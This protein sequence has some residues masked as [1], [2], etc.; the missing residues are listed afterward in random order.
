MTGDNSGV[1][2]LKKDDT[3][4]SEPTDQVEVLN[5]QFVSAVTKEDNISMPIMGTSTADN[6]ATPQALI[7]QVNGVKKLPF[8]SESTQS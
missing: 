4:Y 2:L 7:I 6:C 1:A 5:E 8:W 3:N